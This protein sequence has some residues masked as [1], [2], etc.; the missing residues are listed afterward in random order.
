LAAYLNAKFHLGK[1]LSGISRL[2]KGE[3][4]YKQAGTYPED[5]GSILR[6]IRTG[7]DR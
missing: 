7:F 2:K 5:P 1:D 4:D 6:N 3:R